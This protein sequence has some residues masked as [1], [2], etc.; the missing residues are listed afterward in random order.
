MKFSQPVC[1]A[2]LKDLKD[3]IPYEIACESNG[4]SYNTFCTWLANG[5]RDQ[6]AGKRTYYSQF[7]EAVRK[8]QKERL[9]GHL[10][11]ISESDKGH[12]GSEWILERAYW[13]YYS[14]KT[15][16]I[17]IN[18]RLDA[19]ESKK[20]EADASETK[21]NEEETRKTYRKSSEDA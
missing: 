2:I 12:K 5:K 6:L 7:L 8:I 13:K 9:K 18:E 17:E 14:S 10:G 16:E 19:L 4:V 15:A 21:T 1:D 11:N 20:G 3:E